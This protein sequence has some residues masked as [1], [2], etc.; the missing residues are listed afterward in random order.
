MKRALLLLLALA[1][2]DSRPNTWNA[3]VYPDKSDLSKYEALDGFSTFE[4]CQSA[5][6]T[7]I[8]TYPDPDNADYECGHK[9][10]YDPSMQTNV[11]KETKK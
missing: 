4:Q 9:C 5:A 2:C 1:G 3:Y 6:I 7:R 11:C 8:R 10:R